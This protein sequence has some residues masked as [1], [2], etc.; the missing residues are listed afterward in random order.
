[1]FN[2]FSLP[3]TSWKVRLVFAVLATVLISTIVQQW[4]HH[5][6]DLAIARWMAWFTVIGSAYCLPRMLVVVL[7]GRLPKV[8]ARMSKSW[9]KTLP[10]VHADI[11]QEQQE[12]RDRSR[13]F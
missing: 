13:K 11:A 10:Q 2:V 1:M 3:R 7:F 4:P 12:Q 9:H 5:H 8:Y 6:D